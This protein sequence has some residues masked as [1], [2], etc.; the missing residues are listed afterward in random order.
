MTAESRLF[1]K[2]IEFNRDW[3]SSNRD[4]GDASTVTQNEFNRD[5]GVTRRY[6]EG[7]T[8]GYGRHAP[9]GRSRPVPFKGKTAPYGRSGQEEK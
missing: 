8:K 3:N 5:W 6:L 2:K 1:P 4:S 7:R 9:Y